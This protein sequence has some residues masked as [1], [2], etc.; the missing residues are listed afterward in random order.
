MRYIALCLL[1]AGCALETN[2]PDAGE[3]EVTEQALTRT[4]LG[5]TLP[6][7]CGTNATAV[8]V[9]DYAVDITRDNVYA[10]HYMSNGFP[11]G[12]MWIET[13]YAR[14]ADQHHAGLHVNGQ[15]FVCF[16]A[17]IRLQMD[18]ESVRGG[19][20]ISQ[21]AFA[22]RQWYAPNEGRDIR[23]FENSNT[24]PCHA[25]LARITVWGTTS[26]VSP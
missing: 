20:V 6:V 5:Y 17:D 10:G 19:H 3:V 26:T 22:G 18:C 9:Q 8:E 12:S 4:A 7:R 24:G 15:S 21:L 14:V 23:H 16:L 1:F 13:S 25:S 2:I 11:Y